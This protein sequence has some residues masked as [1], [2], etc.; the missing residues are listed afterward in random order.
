VASFEREILIS[1]VALVLA[2][3]GPVRPAASNR[4]LEGIRKKIENEKKSLSQL[5]AKEGSVLQTLSKIQTD[6]EKR[7]KE[8]SSATTKLASLADELRAQESEAERLG[9]SIAARQDILQKRAAALYRWQ[10]GGSPLMIFNGAVSLGSFLHR[11]KYLSTAISFD[12]ELLANLQEESQ[13]QEILRERL[14][15]KQVELSEQKKTLSLAQASVRQ[16][17]EKKKLLL[18]SLRQ[19]K[20]TRLRA[21]REMEAA[22]Q[23][24]EKMMDEIARRAMIK[25]KQPPST[26][27]TGVGLEA[28]RGKLD[29]PVHGPV[30]APFGKYKH[31]E[32]AAEIF[33][34]GIDIDTPIGEGIRA[35]EKGTIVYADRFS[36]Y[37]K[38]VI[39]DHGERYYTIYGHLSEILKK[40]GDEVKRG[41]VVGR[42]G[43]SDSLAGSKL[44]F[45]MRKDGRSLDPVPWFKK[46]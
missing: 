8:L 29:W 9:D 3:P 13:H 25:P 16:E 40:S 14:A 44:Y 34:K 45:E 31:P 1:C 20:T 5:Q 24:L 37:G 19:E 32:F 7:R 17:A 15:R 28:L 18:A 35:V 36:G 12:R 23:R 10:K 41:E 43:D 22:A 6:L 42:A 26:P 2:V 39:V 38:M 27:S 30:S 4:D 21:L 46:Q 33:R 11:R